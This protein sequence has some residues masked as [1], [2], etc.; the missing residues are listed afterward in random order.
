[1]I[2]DT[3]TYPGQ[4]FVRDSEDVLGL[5]L[6]VALSPQQALT[7]ADRLDAEGA[8]TVAAKGLRR[9]ADRAEKKL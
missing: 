6:N 2:V 4:A 3:D 7:I 8:H 9:A 1:M 5:T